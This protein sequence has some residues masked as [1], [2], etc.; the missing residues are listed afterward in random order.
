[1][2]GTFTI[3]LLET[4]TWLPAA[5]GAFLCP[6]TL[7]PPKGP[8]VKG[9]PASSVPLCS[10]NGQ[11]CQKG[12]GERGCVCVPHFS[13]VGPWGVATSLCRRSQ[14]LLDSSFHP[15]LRVQVLEAAGHGGLGGKNVL[16]EPGWKMFESAIVFKLPVQ[17]RKGALA[18]T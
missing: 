12:R 10:A 4:G 17:A 1:M 18:I 5:M 2:L 8:L 11:C 7:S 3:A 13:T 15:T 6:T 9:L 16:G 14:L